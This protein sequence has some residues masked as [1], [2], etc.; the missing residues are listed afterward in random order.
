MLFTY[1][2][3]PALN[4]LSPSRHRHQSARDTGSA[5][6][7]VASLPYFPA[8]RH[9]GNGGCGCDGGEFVERGAVTDTVTDTVT[10]TDTNTNTVTV[11]DTITGTAPA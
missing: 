8:F 1:P 10:V 7:I 11:T 3:S 6:N 5:E 4:S 2:A 9:D